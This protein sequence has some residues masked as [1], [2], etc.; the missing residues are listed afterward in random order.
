M[1]SARPASRAPEDSKG[2]WDN[3]RSSN[4]SAPS[5]TH[6]W[7]SQV[8]SDRRL[9][10]RALQLAQAI[11]LNLDRHTLEAKFKIEDLS[12]AIQEPANALLAVLC[13]RGHILREGTD[14]FGRMTLRGLLRKRAVAVR[15][16]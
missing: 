4:S 5:A 9:G 8:R 3:I 6:L 15:S 7:L 12:F 2:E 1:N 11:A 16:V 13:S 10:E 14:S